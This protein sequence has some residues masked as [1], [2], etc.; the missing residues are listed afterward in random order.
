M[1]TKDLHLYKVLHAADGNYGNSGGI[2][3]E[4]IKKFILDTGVKTVLDFGCG[5]GALVKLLE[6]SGLDIEVHAYDPAIPGYDTIPLES[7]DLIISTDMFEHLYEDEIDLIFS[8]MIALHPSYMYHVVSHRLAS[9]ILSDG[10]NA[11]KTVQT[12]VWWSEKFSAF[13][14]DYDTTYH[15]TDVGHFKVIKNELI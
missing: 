12:T 4:E 15:F 7:Y 2:Y 5:K 11:H 3:F 13:F 1:K 6:K 8:Q 14:K 9:Q 10:S